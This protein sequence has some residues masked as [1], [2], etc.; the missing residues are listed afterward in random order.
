[1][2]QGPD[3]DGVSAA[4]EKTA[5]VTDLGESRVLGYYIADLIHGGTP[6]KPVIQMVEYFDGVRGV[7][8]F[9]IGPDLLS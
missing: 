9:K 6:S 7:V 8:L 1:M 4:S 2:R 3:A 5:D